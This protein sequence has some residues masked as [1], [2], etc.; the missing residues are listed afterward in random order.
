MTKQSQPPTAEYTALKNAH[1]KALREYN[2]TFLD[3]GAHSAAEQTTWD[4]LIDY[5]ETHGLNY[6]EF[7]PRQ[8][9]LGAVVGLT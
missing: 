6:T 5:V 7:D 1:A 2:M 9:N 4:A 3:S 8:G